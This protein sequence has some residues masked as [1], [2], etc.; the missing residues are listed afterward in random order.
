MTPIAGVVVFEDVAGRDLLRAS[1]KSPKRSLDD[2][3][4]PDS[5]VT[6][7]IRSAAIWLLG[8]LVLAPSC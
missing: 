2:G 6:P 7:Q 8:V 4:H 1:E 5:G 3:S